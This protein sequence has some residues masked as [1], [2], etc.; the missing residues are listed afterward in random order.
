MCYEQ[1]CAATARAQQE[2]ST[3]NERRLLLAGAVPSRPAGKQAETCLQLIFSFKLNCLKFPHN[4]PPLPSSTFLFFL[5]SVFLNGILLFA[6]I[7]CILLIFY[8]YF[9]CCFALLCFALRLLNFPSDPP[10]PLLPLSICH[11]LSPSPFLC[12]AFAC[13]LFLTAVVRVFKSVKSNCGHCRH[14]VNSVCVCDCVCCVCVSVCS[15]Q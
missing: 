3:N 7:I 15:R 8:V 6:I 2:S 10:S 1:Y 14:P 9:C 13:P 4:L 11:S 12:F 5:F